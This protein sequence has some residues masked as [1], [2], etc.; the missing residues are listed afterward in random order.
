[1]AKRSNLQRSSWIC[2][3]LRFVDLLSSYETNVLLMVIQPSSYNDKRL[4]FISSRNWVCWDWVLSLTLWLVALY[5]LCTSLKRLMNSSKSHLDLVTCNNEYSV[6]SRS[7][8]IINTWS[9]VTNRVSKLI[10]GFQISESNFQV[11]LHNF[12]TC[13]KNAYYIKYWNWIL[14]G[15]QKLRHM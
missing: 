3:L 2:K 4:T 15:K 12:L 11:Q 7:I 13:S 9:I 10:K 6:H 8:K 14:I 1:M 5:I